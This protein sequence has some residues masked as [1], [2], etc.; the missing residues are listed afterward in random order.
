MILIALP[1]E[2]MGNAQINSCL[3]IISACMSEGGGGREGQEGGSLKMGV[4]AEGRWMC[5]A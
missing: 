2:G 5:K 3:V 1:K 4:D